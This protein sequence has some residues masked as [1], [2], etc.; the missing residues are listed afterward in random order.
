M[1]DINGLSDEERELFQDVIEQ[2]C[3]AFHK[4]RDARSAVAGLTGRATSYQRRKTHEGES[5]TSADLSLALGALIV[6]QKVNNVDE[7]SIRLTEE[8]QATVRAGNIKS[9]E[10]S[11]GNEDVAGYESAIAH[12]DGWVGSWP[13]GSGTF[14]RAHLFVRQSGRGQICRR[15]VVKDCDY[16]SGTAQRDIWDLFDWFWVKDHRD[17][18]IPV[19]VKTMSDIRGKIGSEFIV[20][21]LN[22]RLA[23]DIRLYR[24]YLEVC[25]VNL[26]KCRQEANRVAV[27]WTLMSGWIGDLLA[28]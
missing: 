7:E 27:C 24:I 20:R 18:D 17:Q 26:L 10:S 23:K 11:V 9:H 5:K 8:W 25:I 22:W 21:I 2:V 1:N 6:A 12:G 15:L 14:G 4:L 19:E 3:K 16:E 28:R 13:L